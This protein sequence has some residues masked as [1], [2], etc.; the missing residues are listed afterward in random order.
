MLMD[1]E[2]QNGVM[3]HFTQYG[4]NFWG[5]P[6]E[7]NFG[8][9]SSNISENIER[10]SKQ[11]M[12]PPSSSTSFLD[13]SLIEEPQLTGSLF[14]TP[15]GYQSLLDDSSNN[16]LEESTSYPTSNYNSLTSSS[17]QSLMQSSV[18][19]PETTSLTGGGLNPNAFDSS[20]NNFS[21]PNAFDS[22]G[23]TLTERMAATLK[24]RETPYESLSDDATSSMSLLS[25]IS[26]NSSQY[27]PSSSTDE[28]WFNSLFG[29]KP[30]F[31]ATLSS[32]GINNE[33][34]GVSLP[35]DE[36]LSKA[37]SRHIPALREY[38]G[39]KDK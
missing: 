29:S 1:Q 39:K 31:G 34:T 19:A 27:E 14:D 28:S 38:E 18:Q 8:F 17:R 32:Q 3:D 35:S 20:L 11:F 10:L 36:E 37:L 23:G 30:A 25:G 16:F 12:T 9:G 15:V 21:Y 6:S 7:N 24:A 22:S 4:H 5:T 13:Q 26:F 33:T 2:K